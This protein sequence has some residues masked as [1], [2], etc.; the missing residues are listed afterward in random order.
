[1]LVN[2][3]I[4]KSR[5]AEQKFIHQACAETWSLCLERK[6][7]IEKI[8]YRDDKVNEKNKKNASLILVQTIQSK[9]KK[10]CNYLLTTCNCWPQVLIYDKEVFL[11]NK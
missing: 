5:V 10:N 11:F 9:Q 7:K 4:S 8:K 1:M 6:N 2:R 3:R